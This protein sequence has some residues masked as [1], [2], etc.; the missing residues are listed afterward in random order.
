MSE[1]KRKVHTDALETLGMII[2]ETAKRDAIHLAV[3]PVVAKE[4]LHPGEHI[5]SDG[6]KRYEV[7]NMDGTL[8]IDHSETVGIVDPFLTRPVEPGEHFWLVLYPRQITS[9]RHVWEHPAFP[10]SEVIEQVNYNNCIRIY[11]QNI[12]QGTEETNE[13]VEASKKW[14]EEY[15]KEIQQWDNGDNPYD[16]PQTIRDYH[17]LMRFA[18]EWINSDSDSDYGKLHFGIENEPL[19]EEFW[20]HYEIVTGR[21]VQEDKKQNFFLCAC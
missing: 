9:L 14:I 3:E 20:H 15:V 4:R 11:P 10:P 7:R 2:D 18:D 12:P 8:C 13:N 1:D 16:A 21:K 17:D 6:T 5:A 19:K